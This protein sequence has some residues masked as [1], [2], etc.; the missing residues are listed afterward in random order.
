[1]KKILS[2]MAAAVALA[3][4]ASANATIIDLFSTDQTLIADTTVNGVGVFSQVST[5]GLDIL[6]GYRD[7]GAE[8]K[9]SSN[10]LTRNANI[11]VDSGFMSFNTSSLASGTGMVRWDGA[12][13][14]TS[15]TD[16]DTT[17]LGGQDIGSLGSSF[18]LDILFADAGFKFVLTA[19]TDSTHWS[20]VELTSLAHVVP[21]SSYIP[22]LAFLDCDNLMGGPLTT[23]GSGGSVDFGNLGALQALIDPDGTFTSLDLSIDNVTTVPEPG[24]LALAGLGLMGLA[25]I[26]RRRNSL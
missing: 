23:C 25:G 2:T 19:W 15:F 7:L 3:A 12:H 13:A 5:G 9:V 4:S 21:G 26:R 11:G 14:A 22:Y 20:S 1:M 16:V 24:S 8:T 10:P 6:G 17:G 18:K